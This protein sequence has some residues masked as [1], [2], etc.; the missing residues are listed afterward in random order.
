MAFTHEH[1]NLTQIIASCA[2]F[3]W[4]FHK[5][6]FCNVFFPATLTHRD[7]FV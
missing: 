1:F 6:K 5:P 2:V 7:L 4:D 3:N